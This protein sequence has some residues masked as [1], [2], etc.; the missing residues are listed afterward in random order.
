MKLQ[1]LHIDGGV[2]ARW[3]YFLNPASGTLGGWDF[4]GL[5]S[6]ALIKTI[7][8]TK[9]VKKCRQVHTATDT[10]INNISYTWPLTAHSR[11]N[12]SSFHIAADIKN[13]VA[14]THISEMNV[15]LQST[16]ELIT[17]HSDSFLGIFS[18][19]YLVELCYVPST[20]QYLRIP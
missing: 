5:K 8:R 17:R 12:A 20:M 18:S 2:Y 3:K 7:N 6:R 19:S 1:P 9:C 11:P 4:V 14:L 13:R 16:W 10:H 15:V